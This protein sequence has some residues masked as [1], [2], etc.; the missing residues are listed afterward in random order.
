[1]CLNKIS[2]AV[3]D[4]IEESRQFLADMTAL[5]QGKL[6]QSQINAQISQVNVE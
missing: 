3:L 6:H 4:E 1:M 5:G 2:S